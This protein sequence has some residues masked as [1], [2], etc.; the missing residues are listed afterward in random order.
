M[1]VG[2][3]SWTIFISE[4]IFMYFLSYELWAPRR[5]RKVDFPRFFYFFF[6][7]IFKANSSSSSI[8]SMHVRTRKIG[9]L[10]CFAMKETFW[11]VLG[12]FPDFRILIEVFRCGFL[13]E[14]FSSV[15]NSDSFP[16][17]SELGKQRIDTWSCPFYGLHL[18]SLFFGTV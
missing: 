6:L 8:V 13:T 2:G 18:G 7:V 16:E 5:V 10:P 14:V 4:L 11:P 12:A 9:S 15:T 1:D 17:K 3:E